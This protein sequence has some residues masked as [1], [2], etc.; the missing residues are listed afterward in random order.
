MNG[1][2]LASRQIKRNPLRS[3]LMAIGIVIAAAGMTAVALVM[4]GVN[5]GIANVAGRLGADVMVIPRGETIAKQFNE[6]LIT[7][8]PATF[9]L[10]PSTIAKV[11]KVPGVDRASSQVFIETLTNARCCAGQFFIVGFNPDTDFTVKPWLKDDLP[12]LNSEMGNWMIVGDRILLRKGE[13]AKF[14]GTSFT[15]AGVLEPTGTGMDWTIYASDQALR[16]LVLTSRTDA[17]TPLKISAGNVSTVLIKAAPGTDL[18]DL[19]EKIEQAAPEAQA[20][21]SSSVAKLA[22]RQ[23]S[24]VAAVLGGVVGGL[25]VM[26]LALNGVVFFMAVRE[27]SSQIGLLVAKGANKGFIFGM[28]MKESVMIAAAAS[29]SGCVLGLLIVLSFRELLSNALGASDVLPAPATTVAFVAAF[30]VL[31]TA[32]AVIAAIVP[33]IPILRTEP[34]EAI[35]AGST[36]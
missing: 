5:E 29:V 35:K 23:L 21:L 26:A 34:Y 12:L 18:I 24:A 8:T 28:L 20:I 14:Y 1:W 33:V 15:V 6:A 25:W 27:R 13:T 32:T 31:A 22:R 7:G 9:Y 4:T 3:G 2:Y 16:Q 36:I 17:E 11:S 30:S 19:A 10:E